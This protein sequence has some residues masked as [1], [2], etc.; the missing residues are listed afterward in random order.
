MVVEL[1]RTSKDCVIASFFD[2]DS[3]MSGHT[4]SD[5][6]NELLVWMGEEYDDLDRAESGELSYPS[7]RKRAVLREYL[8]RIDNEPA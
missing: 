4:P 3:H 1:E 5:A 2:S 6:T 7:I 8:T